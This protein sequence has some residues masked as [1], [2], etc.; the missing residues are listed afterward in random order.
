VDNEAS[1]FAVCDRP[2]FAIPYVSTPPSTAA[3]MIVSFLES[4]LTFVLT[5]K[6]DSR[7]DTAEH[8]HGAVSGEIAGRWARLPV[9]TSTA[10]LQRP[11]SP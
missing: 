11:G 5:V 10:T 3:S 1:G 8:F 7:K 6:P 2:P 9:V 4:G